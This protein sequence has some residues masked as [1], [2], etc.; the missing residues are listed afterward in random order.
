MDYAHANIL[1]GQCNGEMRKVM[2]DID[3]LVC[4]STPRAAYPVPA[5][6]SYGPIPADRDPWTS[7]FTV[8]MD[9]SGQPTIS[10]P[11]GLSANGLPLSV[12]FS[13]SATT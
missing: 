5:S 8:P 3:F 9:Y 4:P 12:Q 2:Q 13:S 1:R 11:C 7:R 6:V 10:L